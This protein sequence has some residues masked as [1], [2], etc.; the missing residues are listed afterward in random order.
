MVILSQRNAVVLFII[1]AI[2]VNCL[3]ISGEYPVSTMITDSDRFVSLKNRYFAM[4]HGQ[5]M[6]NVQAIII[7]DPEVGTRA[8]GLSSLGRDQVLA[9][10]AQLPGQFNDRTKIISSDFLRAR[11]TAQIIADGLGVIEP[12]LFSDKLRERSFGELHGESD[13]R[14][15]DVWDLDEVDASHR[16]FGVEAAVDVV[17]RVTNLLWQLEKRYQG[18]QVLLVA[19]GDVLQLLQTAFEAISPRLHRQLCPLPVAGIRQL[20]PPD[21]F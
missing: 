8:Y 11:E 15:I 6:A 9:A 14:Y 21:Q 19:H 4:R 20:V 2:K 13:S 5:S 3:T 12:I 10:L 18:E 7:S 16:R 1:D 17:G